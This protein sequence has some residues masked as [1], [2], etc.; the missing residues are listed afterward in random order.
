MTN[1]ARWCARFEVCGEGLLDDAL[2]ERA[3]RSQRRGPGCDCSDVVPGLTLGGNARLAWDCFADRA[4]NMANVP[5]Q[6][7]HLRQPLGGT[8]CY[9]EKSQSGAPLFGVFYDDGDFEELSLEGLAER[10]PPHEY[11]VYEGGQKDAALI[12]TRHLPPPSVAQTQDVLDAP[13]LAK[14][15][16][17]RLQASAHDLPDR[18]LAGKDRFPGGESRSNPGRVSRAIGGYHM[19]AAGLVPKTARSVKPRTTS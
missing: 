9:C 19:M 4:H 8:V 5:V 13:A 2:L 15:Q 11:V 6:W 12:I 17:E 16:L 10:L 14:K 18:Q 7:R 3:L 1:Y